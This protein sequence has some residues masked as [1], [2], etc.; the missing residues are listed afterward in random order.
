[1]DIQRL[2][3]VRIE[4][5]ERLASQEEPPWAWFHLM[6]LR[7]ALDQVMDGLRSTTLHPEDSQESHQQTGTRLRL[8][9][10]TD[11]QDS[12]PPRPGVQKPPLP[13]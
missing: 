9:G 3:A 13:M 1:M 8:V 5:N 11:Q 10:H 6:K 12:A 4:V 7:E 2:E